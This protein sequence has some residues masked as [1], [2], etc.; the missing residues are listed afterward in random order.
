MAALSEKKKKKSVLNAMTVSDALGS[1]SGALNTG[2]YKFPVAMVPN[3]HELEDQT[4]TNVLA[5]SS[6]GQ[7]SHIV[8]LG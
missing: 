7:K 6:A 2:L 8:F 4:N 3:H 5:S 1:L